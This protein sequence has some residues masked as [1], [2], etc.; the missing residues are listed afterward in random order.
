MDNTIY[1]NDCVNFLAGL[2][3]EVSSDADKFLL[4]FSIDKSVF[5]ILNLTNQN[6]FPERLKFVLIN[7]AC[8]YYIRQKFETGQLSSVFSFEKAVKSWSMGDTSYT[9]VDSISPE[10]NFRAMLEKLIDGSYYE[11]IK[12]RRINW[13]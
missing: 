3:I 7:M 4:Q 6:E 10:D 8:G 13:S 1:F 2:G 5:R 9:Y 11:I 12:F